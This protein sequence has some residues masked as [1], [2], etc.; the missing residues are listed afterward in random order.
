[1][2]VPR[3]RRARCLLAVVLVGTVVLGAA[4]C[5]DDEDAAPAATSV[6]PPVE[7]PPPVDVLRLGVV[8][9]EHLDPAFVLPG[10]QSSMVAI[11]LLFDGLTAWDPVS[12]APVPGLAE[13]T[14]DPSLTTWTFTLRADA[15][16]SDGS[17]VTAADVKGTLERVARLG[18][19]SL[20]GV[21]LDVVA[22]RA[23]VASGAVSELSG[24]EVIDDQ[25][26]VVRT[27]QAYAALPELLSSPLYGVVPTGADTLPGFDTEPVGSGPYRVDA[28][29]GGLVRLTATDGAGPPPPGAV[30]AIELAVY[31]DAD[32]AYAGFEQGVTDWSVVPAGQLDEAMVA[33][34]DEAVVPLLV[35]LFYGFNLEDPVLSDLALRRAVVQ[36]VDRQALLDT[37]LEA[38]DPLDGV[39]PPSVP[40]AVPGACG[41]ACAFDPEAARRTVTAINAEREIPPLSIDV[42]DDPV[43]RAV[44][45]SIAE[46]LRAVGLS[47]DVSVKPF[48][49]YRTFVVGGE[50]Q[51]FTFGWAGVAADGDVFLA[52][53]LDSASPD[54]PVGLTDPVVDLG[55]RSARAEPDRAARLA[56]Y[57]EIDKAAMAQVPILP[58]ASYRTATVL[59]SRVAGYRPRPDGTFVVE[60]LRVDG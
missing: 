60:T 24:V 14:V 47:V 23:E 49:E 57:G 28:R 22:G 45:E 13:W 43:E 17:S 52:P 19:L 8:G 46:N 20:A 26:V 48:D 39:L 4:G 58:I 3:R 50:Q 27:T 30:E 12:Q 54:N 25:T 41:P 38:A 16:F 35:Q 44:A 29:D 33:Y 7:G 37:L 53:L 55:I 18:D 32:A 51:I 1:M 59:A 31:P 11:D 15:S 5:S 21:R 42:Y 40:G 2:P 36:A 6:P 10:D 56:L 34:G 9:L